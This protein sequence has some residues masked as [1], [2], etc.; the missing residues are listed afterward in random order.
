MSDP[1][2]DVQLTEAIVDFATV[3]NDTLERI[4]G[5]AEDVYLTVTTNGDHAVIE[6]DPPNGIPLYVNQKPVYLLQLDIRCIWN[7]TSKYLAV[8]KSTYQIS[9]IGH[10]E[11]VIRFDYLAEAR[12]VPA[13]HLNIHSHHPGLSEAMSLAKPNSRAY[14]AK[15]ATA[16]IHVPTG[17]R[18]FRPA[19]ED[20][21]EMLIRDF[22]IDRE[23]NWKAAI[24]AG[25]REFRSLQLAAS[26]NDNPDEA[27]RAL[28]ELGYLVEWPHE[29]TEVPNRRDEKLEAF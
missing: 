20:V 13:S 23:P 7:S 22:G 15:G 24:G 18:R 14:K 26:V 17:G 1:L 19:L 10:S 5:K 28:R 6:P 3:M 21:L 16:K 2:E 11:P 4:L 25:R 27:V 29:D 8:R 12:D 9:I